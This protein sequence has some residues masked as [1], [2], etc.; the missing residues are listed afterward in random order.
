MKRVLE[1]GEERAETKRIRAAES[2]C[3]V[4]KAQLERAHAR[5]RELEFVL[6]S[7]SYAPNQALGTIRVF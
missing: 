5:I 2:E 1:E 4:L 3:A 6:Y 7:N